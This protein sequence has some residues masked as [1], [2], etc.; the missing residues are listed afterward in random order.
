[1]SNVDRELAQAVEESEAVAQAEPAPVAARPRTEGKRSLGLLIGLL[2]AAGALLT[3]VFTNLNNAVIY[4]R[5]VDDVIANRARFE[6]RNV[7]VQGMLK[8]GTLVRRDE[9]CEYRF[10]IIGKT[11]ELPVHY[12][13]CTIPD[14]FR[15]MPGM[16]VVATAE[17]T[18]DPSGHLE[19]TTVFAKCP[20]KYEMKD[21]ARKG[22]QAPHQVIGPTSAL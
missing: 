12:A 17:G 14:T 20:S 21:R 15:D 7:R 8:K 6:G 1:M 22:E 19:A 13:R 5:N 10:T 4:D 11:S 16:D 9:P 3:L 18:L 2:V